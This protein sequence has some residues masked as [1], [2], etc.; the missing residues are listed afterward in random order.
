MKKFRFIPLVVGALTLASLTSC[1][2]SSAHYTTGNPVG[3]KVGFIT[4]KPQGVKKVA[5]AG[6]S[7]AAKAGG[8]TKIGTVDIKTYSSG[9]IK[10][11]VTGE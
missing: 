6:I 9:T 4:V 2:M 7:A 3:T 8:I 11:K 5:D 1:V 10:V